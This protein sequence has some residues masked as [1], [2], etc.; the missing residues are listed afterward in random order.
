MSL[1]VPQCHNGVDLC[2][3]PSRVVACDQTHED[4]EESSDSMAGTLEDGV[5]RLVHD[6]EGVDMSY[7][8][9]KQE[10]PASPR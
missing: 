5:M 1:E 4:G 3:A 8:L 10:T 2:G 6:E 9:R 7:F